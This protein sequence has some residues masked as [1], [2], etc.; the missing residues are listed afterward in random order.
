M[1]HTILSIGITLLPLMLP[2]VASVTTFDRMYVFGDSLSDSGNVF[3]VTKAQNRLD[4]TI[5][6]VPP[7][8]P[9]FQGRSSNGLVW[10]DYLANNLGVN[11]IPSTDLAVDSPITITSN[12]EIGVNFLFHGATSNQSVNF[13]FGGA[14]SGLEHASDSPFPG[15]LKQ[16]QTFTDD[17][18]VNKQFAD[19]EALYIIW[20][21]GSN[22]YRFG[23]LSGSVFAENVSKG[24]TSLFEAGARNIIV[25]NVPDLGKTPFARNLDSDTANNLTQLSQVYNTSLATS[26]NKLSQTLPGVNLIPFDVNAIFA[27]AIANPAKFGFT[28]VTEACLDEATLQTCNNP[29]HYLFW[30]NIHP[31]TKAHA[32]LS[33]LVLE[34]LKSNQPESLPEPASTVSIGIPGIAWLL[35]SIKRYIIRG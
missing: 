28:N 6:I 23:N 9:Y 20:A 2:L 15:L 21:A 4:S 18:S 17:L 24:V 34:K 35:S 33:N 29:N 22:D 3:N 7:N 12:N 26:L 11:L 13:A 1:K 25:L 14:T 32:I 31:T 5:P 10:V 16:I 30:D 27:E 19:P 8:P